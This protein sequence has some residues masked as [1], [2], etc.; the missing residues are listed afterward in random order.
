MLKFQIFLASLYR[1]LR[2]AFAGR[3]ALRL[4]IGRECLLEF[5]AR[6]ASAVNDLPLKNIA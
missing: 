2:A 5:H 3:D 6:M 1:R 4:A